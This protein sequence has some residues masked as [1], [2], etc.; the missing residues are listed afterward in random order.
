MDVSGAGLVMV[1][2]IEVVLTGSNVMVVGWLV[3]VANCTC[4][5]LTGSQS[6][7][8]QYD[9]VT[10]LGSILDEL[11]VKYGTTEVSRCAS[12]QRTDTHSLACALLTAGSVFVADLL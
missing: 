12:G 3:A 7:P 5:L 6:A 10:A 9:T 4:W 1:S 8:F 11:I 2:R